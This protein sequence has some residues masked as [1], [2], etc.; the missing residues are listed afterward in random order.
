MERKAGENLPL[1]PFLAC[2]YIILL[3][4]KIVNSPYK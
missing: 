4:L 3:L 2:S 1:G